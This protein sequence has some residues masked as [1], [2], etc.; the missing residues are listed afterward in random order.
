KLIFGLSSAHAAATLAVILVGYN[1]GIIDDAILNG[2]IV[3][4]LIT[5][6]IA[7]FVTEEAGKQVAIEVD[8]DESVMIVDGPQRIL[9]PISNPDTM[10][11]LID[12]AITLKEPKN[13][14]PIIGLTVV[15][16][17]DKAQGKLIQARK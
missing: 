16:D 17:D 15:A 6:L 4:I 1:L 10:E 7:S 12:F 8:A 11:R 14:F 2:T 5:C 3:L 9:V 13:Y